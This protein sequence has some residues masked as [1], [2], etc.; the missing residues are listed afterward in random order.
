MTGQQLR[1]KYPRLELGGSDDGRWVVIFCTW[2]SGANRG[3]R[4]ESYHAARAACVDS[5][6]LHCRGLNYH[7]LEELTAA[8]PATEKLSRSYRRMVADA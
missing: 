7:R 2:S 5:C 4:Y 6:G 3:A 1:A 8:Q